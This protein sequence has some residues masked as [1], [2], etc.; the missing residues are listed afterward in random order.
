[1]DAQ[2]E[3]FGRIFVMLLR[4]KIVKFLNLLALFLFLLNSSLAFGAEKVSDKAVKTSVIYDAVWINELVIA[5]QNGLQLI[6]DIRYWTDG[7]RVDYAFS[8]SNQSGHD[9]FV[10]PLKDQNKPPSLGISPFADIDLK[11]DGKWVTFVENKRLDQWRKVPSGISY[12]NIYTWP[13]FIEP[14]HKFNEDIIGNIG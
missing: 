6:V 7:S 13:L 5:E 1:M 4:E 3:D 11:I 9:I 10:P 12:H 8:F 2:F 14:D